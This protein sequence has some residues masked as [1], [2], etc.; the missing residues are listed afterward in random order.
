L[1]GSIVVNTLN[2]A[3][4]AA[5]QRTSASDDV[6]S[7]AYA[8]DALGQVT[9]VD[10][11]G[12]IGPHVILQNTFDVVGNR[13]SLA[14]TIDGVADFQNS[15]GYDQLRRLTQVLQSHSDPGGV[16]ILPVAEKR[17]D[18]NY[19]AAG[20]FNVI[21]RYADLAGTQLVASSTFIYNSDA[22]LTGLTHFQGA[23]VF[24]DYS[25]TFDDAGRVTTFINPDDTV[26]YSYDDT[27]QLIGADY[28]NDT[29]ADETYSFDANGNRTN[30]G[31][32]TSTNNLLTTNGTFNYEYDAEGNRTQ[33]GCD[34][35]LLTRS[36]S[37][38]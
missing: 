29:Q 32:S 37:L 22:Q 34:P 12:T 20:Q 6:S 16:G 35:I 26:T 3:Y 5:S 4:D 8:F 25:W 7:F 33:K 15:Y 31:Y 2:V 36:A 18:F 1:D 30:T 11:Q 28:L 9:S 10:N 27:G 23:T 21:N 24:A 13:T 17:F 19:D 14:A 38:R